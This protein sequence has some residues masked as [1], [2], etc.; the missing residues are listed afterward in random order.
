[1]TTGAKG[2]LRD[3]S[4]ARAR[5]IERRAKEWTSALVDLGGRNTLLYYK[6]LKQGTLDLGL[7][8]PARPAAVDQVLSGRPVRLS[9]LFDEQD[10]ASAA[11]RARVMSAKAKENFEERGLQTLH[12]GWG[13]ATWANARGTA[14]PQAP[15]LLRQAAL[16]AKGATADDFELSL[17]GEWEV[18]P[19]L[20]HLLRTDYEVDVTGEALLAHLD[21][22]REPPEPTGLFTQLNKAARAVPDFAVEPRVVIGNFSYANLPMVLDLESAAEAL[23]S[24]TIVAAL[25]GDEVARQAVRERHPR[26]ALSEP[27]HMPPDE[28]FLILDADASQSYAINVVVAGADLVIDGPPGTG[29]SQTIANLIATLCARGKKVLFVAEKRAAIDAVLDRLRKV[30]LDELV[31]DLH[32]GMTSKRRLATELARSLQTSASLARPE[33]ASLHETLTRHRSVLVE[34]VNALHAKREPWAVSVYDALV[35]LHGI[36]EA[37]RSSLRLHGDMLEAFDEAAFHEAQG[38]VEELASLGG[39]GTE[40]AKSPWAA[41]LA[42]RTIT[43]SSQA[44]SARDLTRQLDKELLPEASRRVSVALSGC[45][46]TFSDQLSGWLE[47]AAVLDDVAGVLEVFE[48]AIF[49]EDL[50]ALARR[51]EPASRN[52]AARLLAGLTDAA[53]RRARRSATALIRPGRSDKQR[54]LQAAVARAA[55]VRARWRHHSSGLIHLPADMAGLAGAVRQLARELEI[56]GRCLGRDDLATVEMSSLRA[57]VSHLASDFATLARLPELSRRLHALEQRGLGAFVEEA[58]SRG[59]DRAAALECLEHVWLSSVFEEVALADRRV[60]AFDGD[61]HHHHVHEFGRADEMHVRANA[62]RVRRLVAER[63]TAV[64]DEFPRESELVEHQARLKRNHLAP[65]QLFQM[66]PHVIGA[67]K[68]CWVMSP[69]VVAQLLPAERCFDVVVFDEASQ[70]PPAEAIGALYRADQAIVA[71]DVHQLPP[72]S[73]FSTSGDAEDDDEEQDGSLEEVLGGTK[74]MESILEAMGALLPPPVGTRTLS[75]HYRS[76]DERLIAFSNAQPSLYHSSLITFPGVAGDECLRHVPVPFEE[77]RSGQEESAAAEVRRVVELV[78]EHVEQRP[79]ESLGVITMGSKHKNRITEALRLARAEH[80]GLNAFMDTPVS[81]DKSQELFFVKNLERVQGDERDA[82]ILTIGYG[83]SA[84]GRMLYRFGP[85]NNEG[86][87]RRLNV[88]ITRA[89]SHMTV[90]SSFSSSDID[91]NRLKAEGA[92]LLWRYLQYAESGGRDLGEV[93]LERP[94]LNAFERDVEA[95]LTSAG[96]PLLAQYG[97]SGYWIDFAAQ[98]PEKPGQMV[99]AIECDGATYHSSATARERDRLRQQHLERLGWTFHRIWSQDWFHHHER[100]VERALAAYHAAVAVANEKL[101]DAAARASSRIGEEEAHL[102]VAVGDGESDPLRAAGRRGPCPVDGGRRHITEY[103]RSELVR[104]VR[105][106]K[107]DGLLR[108]EQELLSEVMRQLG[109]QRR[110]SR[111]EQAITKVIARDRNAGPTP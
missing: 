35:R 23:A 76:K 44:K 85:V 8:S 53:Y 88:A 104:V 31:L 50:D 29:K 83:K 109:F 95:R 58:R 106:V 40:L 12:L 39:L 41:A 30:G 91:P 97:C 20:L 63:A 9:I 98:H 5:L 64:R 4:D 103:S 77:E 101:Q 19:S 46:L 60:G 57:L 7:A 59:L 18:N 17:S 61:A 86:G 10:L 22:D 47:L 36:P 70:V 32:D 54:A 72:T 55:A 25:A 66:A 48:P 73:F 84:D 6:D 28:E 81:P 93:N 102:E 21:E 13:M 42:A 49:E 78:I 27:D 65:R 14:I 96:V 68:P 75:W 92:R 90:V 87:E 1:M 34:R 26:L 3:P 108:T 51:L 74:D 71:G 2:A 56:L 110:G 67:L 16:A 37:S 79:H 89:R 33:V 100:E 82:I 24:S 52:A 38:D 62:Q 105:W 80:R 94:E 45:G 107:S 43:T 111:I 11:R 15:V 99:L 69:L